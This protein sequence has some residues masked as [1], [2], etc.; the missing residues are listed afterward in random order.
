MSIDIRR[1]PRDTPRRS[2]QM[3]QKHLKRADAKRKMGARLPKYGCFLLIAI[4]VVYGVAGKSA[5][6]ENTDTQ[7]HHPDRISSS[8]QTKTGSAAWGNRTNKR[9]IQSLIRS[10]AFLNLRHKR[11]D[12]A[13]NGQVL[14]VET[15]ID[16]S[17]QNLLLDKIDRKNSE[18]VG[19]VAMDPSTGRILAMASYNRR[20]PFSNQCTTALFPAASVFKIVTAAAGIET[21]DYHLDSYFTFNGRKHTLYKSQLKEQ[22]D[23]YTNLITF[24]DSFAQ[25]VNPVFGKMGTSLGRNI[26]HRYA[27]AFGFNHTIDFEIPISPSVISFSDEPY[28]WA[29]VASGFNRQTSI[30]PIHGAVIAATILNQGISI[31]PTLVD[32]VLGASGMLVYS[33]H[34]IRGNRTITPE[35]SAILSDL[36]VATVNSGTGRETFKGHKKNAV[37][38]QLRIGG[39]TGSI[40]NKTQDKRYDWFVGFAEEKDGSQDLVLSIVV[41][42]GKYI[43]TRAGR[44]ARMA[45]EH[46]FGN[47]FVKIK[48]VGAGA[49]SG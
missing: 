3:Y 46:F 49:E 32:R 18:D 38:S 29:E 39:K 34:A 40:N 13:E 24:Q 5:R 26:L 9:E 1:Y 2:W 7:S 27:E 17:L 8:N 47:Y 6:T 43:G 28:Q 16:L 23:R 33:S 22:S 31:E 20:D 10:D 15:S 21:Y 19:I 14:H 37:L 41:A 42:H 45:I 35:A 4:I 12:T 48:P 30:S 11:F 44:Y 25:S 36:M